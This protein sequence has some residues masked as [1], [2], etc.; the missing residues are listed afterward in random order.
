MTLT[1]ITSFICALLNISYTI[2]VLILCVKKRERNEKKEQEKG[3]SLQ[4]LKTP[5]AKTPERK[6]PFG[7]APLPKAAVTKGSVV[8]ANVPKQVLQQ[9]PTSVNQM[10]QTIKDVSFKKERKSV[11]MSGVAIW[12]YEK[13]DPTDIQPTQLSK[14]RIESAKDE[15]KNL[16]Q[17]IKDMKDKKDGQIQ[18]EQYKSIKRRKK[19]TKKGTKLEV[20]RTQTQTEEQLK[21]DQIAK[22]EQEEEEEDD[23]MKGIASLQQDLNIVSTEE[24]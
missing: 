2:A 13:K 11:R 8:K 6:Q 24:K 9:S 18:Y 20:A 4:Q 23:T 22:D 5:E 17:R 16:L 1:T 21:E 10:Q 3:A 15:Q 14:E 7:P 19:V 12:E